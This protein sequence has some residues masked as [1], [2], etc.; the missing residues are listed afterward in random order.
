MSIKVISVNIEGDNHFD[1]VFAFIERE[2]PDVVCMQEVYEV[3]LPLFCTRLSPTYRYLPLS[4][5]SAPNPFRKAQKGAEG[6]V[7]F[8]KLPIHDSGSFYYESEPIDTTILDSRPEGSR[9]GLVWIDIE[10]GGKI[11][12]IATTHF[13][14]SWKGEVTTLQKADLGNLMRELEA[15]KP[16]LLCG[17]FN[18]PRGSEIFDHLATVFTDMI[19]P[20]VTTTIDQNLHRVSGI[21]FV[22]D[23][24]FVAPGYTASNVRV[25]DGVSDHCALVG[26]LETV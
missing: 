20:T 3:D 2:N 10:V 21:Q 22:V 24:F 18:T 19:P 25:L 1:T 16:T 13:T 5:V 7:I 14:W 9:R 15:V 23:G 12:R 11:Y 4:T 17:D 26:E 8:S 6:V